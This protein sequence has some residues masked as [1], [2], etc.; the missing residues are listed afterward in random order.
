MVNLVQVFSLSF[1]GIIESNYFLSQDLWL[2]TANVDQDKSPRNLLWVWFF[3]L[4]NMMASWFEA[5][6]FL[7]AFCNFIFATR[8]LDIFPE[9]IKMILISGQEERK[10]WWFSW[11]GKQTF[12]TS[13]NNNEPEKKHQPRWKVYIWYI[14]TI[15]GF[16]YINIGLFEFFVGDHLMLLGMF[17]TGSRLATK[18]TVFQMSVKYAS[19]LSWSA[20][21]GH[22]LN[23]GRILEL[24]SF[25]KIDNLSNFFTQRLFNSTIVSEMMLTGRYEGSNLRPNTIISRNYTYQKTLNDI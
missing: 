12:L 4:S 13:R 17:W 25:L 10:Q 20:I 5:R 23:L 6:N 8:H 15:Q 1:G 24:E 7:R 18:K 21:S 11:P 22:L 14:S 16:H 2:V 3:T 9:K 19:L